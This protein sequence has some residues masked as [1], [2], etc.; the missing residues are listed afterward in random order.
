MGRRVMA[1][2][3]LEREISEVIKENRAV[4]AK[5]FDFFFFLQD[6]LTFCGIAVDQQQQFSHLRHSPMVA[7]KWP[8][9]Y[10]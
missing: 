7:L 6:P 4:L 8:N 10:L 5:V 9:D 2:I 1:Q 3:P